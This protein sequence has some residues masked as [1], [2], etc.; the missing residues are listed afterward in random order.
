M[1]GYPDI[2]DLYIYMNFEIRIKREWKWIKQMT[3]GGKTRER[4]LKGAILG[5]GLQRIPPL[6]KNL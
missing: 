2:I 1:I 5:T 3:K 6:C 4:D